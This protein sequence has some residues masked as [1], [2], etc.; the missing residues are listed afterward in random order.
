MS[1]PLGKVGYHLPRTI[2][3]AMTSREVDQPEP[4]RIR[5]RAQFEEQQLRQ[6]HRQRD[7]DPV[8]HPIA[9]RIGGSTIPAHSGAIELD[10]LP[11]NEGS[12]SATQSKGVEIIQEHPGGQKVDSK[13][14]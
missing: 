13:T 11:G 9:F 4:F 5:D 10:I 6:R 3:S 8:A 12:A 7:S 14:V 1:V 2:S